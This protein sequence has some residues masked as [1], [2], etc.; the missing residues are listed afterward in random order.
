MSVVGQIEHIEENINHMPDSKAGVIFLRTYRAIKE[1]LKSVEKEM[2]R[3]AY[4]NGMK[5]R[6][7]S[8]SLDKFFNF[9]EQNQ[10]FIDDK[11]YNEYKKLRDV[12]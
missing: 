2:I 5:G 1:D 12:H 7:N 11:L 9:M 3:I 6:V 4:L 8:S 10:Y